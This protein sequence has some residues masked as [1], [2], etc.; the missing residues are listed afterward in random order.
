MGWLLAALIGLNVA[1]TAAVWRSSLYDRSQVIRQT[2]IVWL[3]PVVGA[4][5]VSIAW[6][7]AREDPAKHRLVKEP[8]DAGDPPP[9][10]NRANLPDA[11]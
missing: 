1:V 11:D 5:I 4:V 7:S 3:L 10:F 6:W 2:G 8:L 9:N